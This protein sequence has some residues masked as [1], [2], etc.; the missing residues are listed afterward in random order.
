MEIESPCNTP[1]FPVLKADKS[2]YRLVHDLR[3]IN[4]VVEDRSSAEM[5]NL[6]T[7][8]TAIPAEAKFFTVIDLC[9]AFFTIPVAEQS[10]YLFA[11]TYRGKKYSYTRLPQG[12][13]HSPHV[14]NQALRQDLEG[15]EIKS[16]L[17]QFVD[18]ILIHW[19]IAITI[20]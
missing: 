10:Q 16:T 15:L 13:K 5:P 12:F 7:L 20:Q 2:K 1:I 3:T 8:L 19:R 11:F 9:S 6:H 17:L 18:D 4:D 14:F